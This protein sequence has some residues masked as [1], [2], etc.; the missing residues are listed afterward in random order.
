MDLIAKI[1]K[2]YKT[3]AVV[4]ASD[5]PARPSNQVATYL[6]RQGFRVIPVNPRLARV[7]GETCYPDLLSIPEPIEVVDIFRNPEFVSEIVEQAIT[8][9]V[10]VVW[11]QPG[12]ENYPAAQRAE[13]AGL[14]VV[15]SLCMMTAHPGID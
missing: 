3:I 15:M 6:Q 2:E 7:H 12:A 11:M 14:Q 4:G 1:F 10:K 8:K 9:Q 5:N 13:Q